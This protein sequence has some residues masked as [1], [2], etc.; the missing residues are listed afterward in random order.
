MRTLSAAIAI[1]ALAAA[2]VTAKPRIQVEKPNHDYG[3][4]KEGSVKEITHEF[5]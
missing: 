1:L 3:T 4:V 5:M 2:I